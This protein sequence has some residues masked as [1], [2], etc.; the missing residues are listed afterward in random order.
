MRNRV[1]L[2]SVVGLALMI[3]SEAL[4]HTVKKACHGRDRVLTTQRLEDGTVIYNDDRGFFG[5]P[6]TDPVY[7]TVGKERRLPALSRRND[8]S[9]F[10]L[11][12]ESNNHAGLQTGGDHVVLGET[13]EAIGETD[14]CRA[15]HRIKP[16]K[17]ATWG[18]DAILF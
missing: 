9:G 4:T 6:D 18:Y 3:P 10:W 16:R 15:T 14:P 1:L 13:G 5:S 11:Y 8:P 2:A 17:R 12:V 7:D